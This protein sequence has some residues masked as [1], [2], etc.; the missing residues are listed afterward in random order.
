MC[1][2][3]P[4]SLKSPLG[5]LLGC[6]ASTFF[7]DIRNVANYQLALLFFSWGLASDEVSWPLNNFLGLVS[8]TSLEWGKKVFI[9]EYL[10]CDECESLSGASAMVFGLQ[11]LW[12][13]GAPQEDGI[14]SKSQQPLKSF[15]CSYW[16]WMSVTSDVVRS[17]NGNYYIKTF[18]LVVGGTIWKNLNF[19]KEQREVDE[20]IWGY[21]DQSLH[22]LFSLPSPSSKMEKRD[23]A[24]DMS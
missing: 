19:F 7:K 15:A 24:R 3:P 18:H 5:T 12:A 13:T 1:I 6:T 2:S 9:H 21:N 4:A 17:W 20:S 22:C 8:D 23:E 11:S 16:V 14:Q 10:L